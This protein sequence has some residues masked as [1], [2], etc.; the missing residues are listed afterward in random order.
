MRK[1]P[2]IILTAGLIA[3]GYY[4]WKQKESPPTPPKPQEPW[5]DVGEQVH[6]YNN[7]PIYSN[8][9]KVYTSYGKHYAESGYYYGRKWQCVEFVKRYYH[10]AHNHRMPNVWGHAKSF[11]NTTV[12]HGELNSERGMRQ[13]TNGSTEKPEV[14]DLLVWNEGEYGHVAIISEVNEDSITVVQQNIKNAAT[15]SYPLTRSNKRFT[16][17]SKPRPAGWLRRQV[18]SAEPR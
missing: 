10:D 17:Q 2:I 1:A 8:G 5:P 18:T 12:K 16:I 7:V 3:L 14:D 11:F 4:S 13:F 15:A 9:E 6:S